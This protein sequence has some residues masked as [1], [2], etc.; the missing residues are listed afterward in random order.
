MK[1]FGFLVWA[2]RVCD[3]VGFGCFGWWQGLQLHPNFSQSASYAA[4]EA[5]L[6]D[7]EP[8][9]SPREAVQAKKML[10]RKPRVR[11]SGYRRVS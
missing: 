8:S 10:T 9:A 2:R 1:V 11:G 7:A 4:N 6:A 5:E 3:L